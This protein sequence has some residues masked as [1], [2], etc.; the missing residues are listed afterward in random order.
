VCPAYPCLAVPMCDVQCMQASTSTHAPLMP[1]CARACKCQIICMVP[2][3]GPSAQMLVAAVRVLPVCAARPCPR[4][5][6]PTRLR[7][8]R[9][10]GTRASSTPLTSRTGLSPPMCRPPATCP[11]EQEPMCVC[12]YPCVRACTNPCTQAL[13][14]MCLRVYACAHASKGLMRL[15]VKAPE[16]IQACMA[17]DANHCIL[18]CSI[19]NSLC[20]ACQVRPMPMPPPPPPQPARSVLAPRLSRW[21]A[22]AACWIQLDLGRSRCSSDR[23]WD[24]L[25]S[26]TSADSCTSAR[27]GA[28]VQGP[29][30]CWCHGSGLR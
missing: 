29:G 15:L 7:A 27:R 30:A 19:A 24:L 18:V 2:V 21:P 28:L 6:V 16:P 12:K 17:N 10:S 11:C 5:A 1:T 14:S 20:H 3:P 22:A 23:S 13:R 26:W 25:D 4:P 9:A 8:R